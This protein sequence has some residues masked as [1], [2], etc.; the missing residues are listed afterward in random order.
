MVSFELIFDTSCHSI[1]A[2]V[3]EIDVNGVLG[4]KPARYGGIA[5]GV[6]LRLTGR[7][8]HW[9]FV[10][11]LNWPRWRFSRKSDHRALTIPS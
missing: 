8:V 9:A 2:V 7:V 1:S 10:F 3:R 11:R 6:A 5:S 4:L